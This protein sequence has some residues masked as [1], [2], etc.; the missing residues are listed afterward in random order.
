MKMAAREDNMIDEQ[1]LAPRQCGGQ[2]PLPFLP[3]LNPT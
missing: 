1:C 2:M 3:A